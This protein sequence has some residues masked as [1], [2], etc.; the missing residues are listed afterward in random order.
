MNSHAFTYVIA[1]DHPTIVLALCQIVTKTFGINHDQLIAFDNGDSLVDFAIKGKS[2]INII[3]LDL[4]MPGKLKGLNL[5]RK[6]I[7]VDPYSR[8]IVYTAENSFFLAKSAIIAGALCFV[9]KTSLISEL[10]ESIASVHMNIKYIDRNIDMDMING[11]AWSL[12]T[13]KERAILIAFARGDKIH[14][15][16]KKTHRS[17]S[18]VATH[19]NNALNKLG[20]KNENSVLAYMY[21]NGL[22]HEIEDA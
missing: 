10:R 6:I 9:S 11:H 22:A 2:G 8:V 18:T 3:I 1:D 14:E 17:Y 20:L 16:A 5:L 15:I 12:L 13:K 4:M 7:D 21:K 19:K